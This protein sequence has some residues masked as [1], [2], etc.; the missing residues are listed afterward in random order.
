MKRF[1]NE[2]KYMTGEILLCLFLL[3]QKNMIKR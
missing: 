2:H 1:V 3:G